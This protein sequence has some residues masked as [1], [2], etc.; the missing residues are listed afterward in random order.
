MKKIL[1]FIALLPFLIIGCGSSG[2]SSSTTGQV[3][4]KPAVITKVPGQAYAQTQ[5]KLADGGSFDSDGDLASYQWYDQNNN[6]IS[7]DDNGN[8]TWIAPEREGQYHLKLK[9]FDSLGH[10]SSAS[11]II[12]VVSS[13]DLKSLI[14]QGGATYI[15]VG[16]STRAI[17]PSGFDGGHVFETVKESLNAYNVNSIL[18]A[19]HGVTSR[20]FNHEVYKNVWFDWSNV[21]KSIP[22]SGETTIVDITLGINDVRY[23]D[24]YDIY[25]DLSKAIAKIKKEK[26]LTRFLLT[27]PNKIVSKKSNYEKRSKDISNA[28]FRLSQDLALPIIDTMSELFSGPYDESMYRTA[29]GVENVKSSGLD[30]R[31]HLSIKAQK[32]VAN[33]ILDQ[34]LP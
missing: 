22:K 29:D 32:E 2:G 24:D 10:S 4:H 34:L 20:D 6:K 14:K 15:C 8:A 16:D 21:V 9:V 19:K 31:L 3:E 23:Y 28:Y 13:D 5:V 25:S 11:A 33:L 17:A 27:M 26:P 30:T 18:F 12:K 7:T 1:F